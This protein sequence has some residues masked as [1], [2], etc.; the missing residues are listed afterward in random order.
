MRRNSD[1]NVTRQVSAFLR[2]GHP[3][4]AFWIAL[5]SGLTRWIA[6]AAILL[7]AYKVDAATLLLSLI[8]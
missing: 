3:W 8:Q 5:Q 2:H 6:G 7:G 4:L 1:E